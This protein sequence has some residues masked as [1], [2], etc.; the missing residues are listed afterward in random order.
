MKCPVFMFMIT[1]NNDPIS[2]ERTECL[3]RKCAWFRPDAQQCA[4]LLMTLDL[5]HIQLRLGEL[6]KQLSMLRPQ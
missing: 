6:A 3:G 2:I 5:E 1:S 4:V